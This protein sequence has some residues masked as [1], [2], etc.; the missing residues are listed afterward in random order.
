MRIDE[1]TKRHGRT[2]SDVA[3]KIGGQV[4]IGVRGKIDATGRTDAKEA[5]DRRT[6]GMWMA[7]HTQEEI[8]EAEDLNPTDKVLRISGNLADL[9]KNQKAAAEHVTDFEPPLYN[10]WKQQT[11]TEGSSHFGNSEVR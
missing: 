10:I 1:K 3:N 6:F 8:A 5:R 9:P 2:P 7:C 11:K 4:T